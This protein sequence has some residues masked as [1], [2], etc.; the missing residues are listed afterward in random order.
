[1]KN[2]ALVVLLFSCAAN[3]NL[4]P[5]DSKPLTIPYSA[6]YGIQVRCP[7][8]EPGRVRGGTAF[9]VGPHR[10]LTAR[11]VVFCNGHTP[12]TVMLKHVDSGDLLDAEVDT[13]SDKVDVASVRVHKQLSGWF[14]IHPGPAERGESLCYVTSKGFTKC[15]YVFASVSFIGLAVAAVAGN[16]GSPVL[17]PAGHVVAVVVGT[18][19][20]DVDKGQEAATFS[21]PA[22]MWA[23]LVK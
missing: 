7:Q 14:T 4:L 6:V 20:I 17:D 10:M 5:P 19:E 1:M 11:H 13:L 3:V 21:I 23:E 8:D 16:S 2:A 9:A 12:D 18:M 22:D 15:G